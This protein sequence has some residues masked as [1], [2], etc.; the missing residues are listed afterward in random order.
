ME[1]L[2]RR[3]ERCPVWIHFGVSGIEGGLQRMNI[4]RKF[5]TNDCAKA[6][7]ALNLFM[8]ST[9]LMDQLVSFFAAYDDLLRRDLY[10]ALH[11]A[12]HVANRV[13]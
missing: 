10:P 9:V 13:I 3:V 6:S 5:G 12:E 7:A 8:Q 4:R 11:P 2:Q 1:R